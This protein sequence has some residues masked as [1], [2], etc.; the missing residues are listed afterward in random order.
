VPEIDGLPVISLDEAERI[1]LSGPEKG[2]KNE[3]GFLNR[4]CS[5]FRSNFTQAEYESVSLR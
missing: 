3:D 1:L 2:L 5:N 4:S